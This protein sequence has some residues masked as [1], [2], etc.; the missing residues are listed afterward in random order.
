[1]D[2]DESGCVVA[3]RYLRALDVADVHL[4]CFADH[5]HGVSARQQFIPQSER[6]AQIE[7]VLLHAGEHARCAG[8]HLCLRHIRAGTDRLLACVPLDLMTCINHDDPTP[9]RAAS[10][11]ADI[12]TGVRLACIG[13]RYALC[14]NRRSSRHVFI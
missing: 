1:M 9:V 3:V 5:D 13:N 6:H 12:R 7:F 4:V 10:L 14:K 11:I 8:R 2:T